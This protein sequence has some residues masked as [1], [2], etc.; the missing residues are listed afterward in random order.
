M[1]IFLVLLAIFLVL[2]SGRLTADPAVNATTTD[3]ET[4]SN[5]DA[6]G[7]DSKS[8]LRTDRIHQTFNASTRSDSDD[9]FELLIPLLFITGASFIIWRGIESRRD[10]RMAMIEK[11]MEPLLT[12]ESSDESSKKFSALRFGMLLTGVGFGLLIAILIVNIWP[13]VQYTEGIF[14]GSS[15]LYGGVGLMAYHVIARRLEK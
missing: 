14:V 5:G 12:R 15:L 13:A 10:V 8:E 3:T 4:V 1:R 11:G 7:L 9:A 2:A 6:P